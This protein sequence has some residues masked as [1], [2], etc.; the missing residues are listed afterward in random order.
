MAFYRLA[1][2]EGNTNSQNIDSFKRLS[3][4]KPG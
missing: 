1:G 2:R 4:K 3:L